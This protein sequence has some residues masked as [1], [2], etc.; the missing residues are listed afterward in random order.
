ML[1]SISPTCLAESS[2][3]APLLRRRRRGLRDGGGGPIGWYMEEL[4]LISRPNNGEGRLVHSGVGQELR[5][6]TL[7]QQVVR[8]ADDP[9][10]E[11]EGDGCVKAEAVVSI[12]PVDEP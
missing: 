10:I 6:A 9:R 1:A 5:F 8:H 4:G 3:G 12:S 11:V 7:A 2:S